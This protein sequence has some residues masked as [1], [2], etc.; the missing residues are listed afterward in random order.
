[1]TQG[2]PESAYRMLLQDEEISSEISS[3]AFKGLD[4][5]VAEELKKVL[6]TVRNG[7]GDMIVSNAFL[8][9]LRISETMLENKDKLVG[10]RRAGY[11][12]KLAEYIENSDLYWKL[13]EQAYVYGEGFGASYWK[14]HFEKNLFSDTKKRH[15]FN[16]WH[17]TG[18]ADRV[19]RIYDSLDSKRGFTAYRVFYARDG[20]RVRKELDKADS[21]Y[22]EHGEGFGFSYSL[23]NIFALQFSN[24]GMN[25]EVLARHSGMSGEEIELYK[26]K[27]NNNPNL[28]HHY[29]EKYK[30]RKF[31]GKYHVEKRDVI[32]LAFNRGEEEV[33]A[34]KA[35]LISYKSVNL[36]DYIIAQVAWVYNLRENRGVELS[37]QKFL[38]Q[39]KEHRILNRLRGFFNQLSES[40]QADVY[41]AWYDCWDAN[42]ARIMRKHRFGTE[43][44]K[45]LHEIG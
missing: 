18:G 31:I 13:L 17:S 38:Y 42:D 5:N 23:S 24:Y 20:R 11:F 36:R 28:L 8:K 1:M 25:D 35:K 26:N 34:R 9:Y 32:S 27:R 29:D 12:L 40:E 37:K 44:L 21:S 19:N 15:V 7:A 45:A 6:S 14:S 4:D 39:H 30:N 22:Y 16:L 43:V 33:I 2:N 3:Q 41:R 10:L